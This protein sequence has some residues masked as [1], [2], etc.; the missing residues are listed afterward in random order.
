MA[1]GAAHSADRLFY[2][3]TQHDEEGKVRMDALHRVRV[4]YAQKRRTTR[5]TI[6]LMY[7]IFAWSQ[8]L[9]ITCMRMRSLT[10]VCSPCGCCSPSLPSSHP[11][12]WNPESISIVSKTSAPVDTYL[13]GGCVCVCDHARHATHLYHVLSSMLGDP[14]H[15]HEIPGDR[16]RSSQSM[17]A[18]L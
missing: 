1:G 9:L 10:L 3:T 17:T 5:Y 7:P 11:P 8:Y 2:Y 12:A 13:L 16:V 4:R 6:L 14:R 18:L 15:Q